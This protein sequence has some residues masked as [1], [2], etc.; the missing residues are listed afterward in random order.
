M[1]VCLQLVIDCADG[2]SEEGLD[3]CAVGMKNREGNE[4][5]IN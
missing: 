4:F 1:P 5:D 3:H 2:L